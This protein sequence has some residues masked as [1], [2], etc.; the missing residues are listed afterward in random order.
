MPFLL[1]NVAPASGRSHI[2]LSKGPLIAGYAFVDYKYKQKTKRKKK[3]LGDGFYLDT[4]Y[5]LLLP[6]QL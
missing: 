5:K 3:H 6:A 1:V 2:R 4:Y